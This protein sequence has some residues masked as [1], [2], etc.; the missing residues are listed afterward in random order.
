MKLYTFDPAPNPKRLADFMA[1]KGIAI[2]TTQIDMMAGEQLGDDYLKIN[3]AGT[4]PALV[5]DDGTVLT[6]VIGICCYLEA[7]YPEK[8]LLGTTALEKAL[9]ISWSHKLFAMI[10]IAVADTLRNRSPSFANRALP[11]PLDVPQIEALVERG[12]LRLNYAW[13][14]IEKA[15]AGRD[16]LAG[17][18]ISQADIDLAAC[19]GFAGWVKSAPGEDFP[20]TLAHSA[21]VQAAL[22]QS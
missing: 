18:N 9:V 15:L 13:P 1:Y 6:E 22:A 19:V 4:V 11:G 16:W 10:M 17:E 8:P 2:A 3:P 7:L 5:L 21:R 12:K 20:N 14:E